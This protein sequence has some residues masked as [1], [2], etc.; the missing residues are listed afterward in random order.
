MSELKRIH[1]WNEVAGNTKVKRNVDDEKVVAQWH[2]IT[3]EYKELAQSLANAQI[4]ATTNMGNVLKEACDCIVVITGLIN[5]LGYDTDTALKLV[6][7][8]NFSKF[9]YNLKDVEDSM[10]AYEECGRYSDVFSEHI[11]G[12]YVIKGVVKETGSVKILK[13]I[14]YKECNMRD[15]E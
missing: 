3:E 8:S 1:E 5:A 12:L 11:N 7:D 14:N 2:L 10:S 6:N 9:C 15:I 13:G 4:N